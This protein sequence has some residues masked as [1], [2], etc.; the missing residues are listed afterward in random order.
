MIPFINLCSEVSLL[1]ATSTYRLHV[2]KFVQEAFNE[3]SFDGLLDVAAEIL[4]RASA[5]IKEDRSSSS[6][7]SSPETELSNA[8]QSETNTIIAE[9]I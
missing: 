1:L 5:T 6:S 2:R 7:T 9:V 8:S 3:I 4:S